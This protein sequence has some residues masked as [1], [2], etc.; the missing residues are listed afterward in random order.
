MD[1][2]LS[3]GVIASGGVRSTGGSFDLHG[4][5]GQ[6][7][8]DAM[9]GGAL[10]LSGGFWFGL[11][12]ADCNSDGR[13]DAADY[14]DFANCLVGPDAIAPPP[15]CSCLD[16]DVDGDEDLA[17]FAYFQTAFRK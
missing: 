11:E 17:D 2:E 13:I 1:V 8:S 10:T 16:L 6:G 4:T 14:T 5:A 12:P 9:Q 3:R 15:L 7:A